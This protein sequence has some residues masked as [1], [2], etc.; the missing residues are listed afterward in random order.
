MQSDGEEGCEEVRSRARNTASWPIVPL[1]LPLLGTS[2]L[3][4]SKSSIMICGPH[5]EFLSARIDVLSKIE[6]LKT[7]YIHMEPTHIVE[8]DIV[9][10]RRRQKEEIKSH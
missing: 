2:T 9:M 7:I 3:A 5:G 10:A 4:T 8:E 6:V 1:H